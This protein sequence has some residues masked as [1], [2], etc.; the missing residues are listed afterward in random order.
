MTLCEYLHLIVV[1]G[2]NYHAPIMKLLAL[3]P[4]GVVVFDIDYLPPVYAKLKKKNI[5]VR[6]DCELR[7]VDR[8]CTIVYSFNV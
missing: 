6:I 8:Y 2:C 7:I 3:Q 5:H 1:H 4:F